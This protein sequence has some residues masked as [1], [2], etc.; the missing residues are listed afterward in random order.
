MDSRGQF[1]SS[2]CLQH[3]PFEQKRCEFRHQLSDTTL[4]ISVL[5]ELATGTNRSVQGALANVDADPTSG[6][7]HDV[8]PVSHPIT[9]LFLARCGLKAQAIVRVDGVEQVWRPELFTG[10]TNL[11]GDG[12]PHLQQYK[13]A[14]AFGL[15]AVGRIT[16]WPGG[17]RD[18]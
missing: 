6:L 14:L 1:Q 10:L 18:Q 3:H 7:H 17:R 2:S 4:G 16:L 12:L 9:P 8:S 11:G 15:E 5:S 13:G